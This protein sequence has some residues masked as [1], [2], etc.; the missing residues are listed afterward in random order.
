MHV[1]HGV[2]PTAITSDLLLTKKNSTAQKVAGF[3]F[4]YPGN[5]VILS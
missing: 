4:I 1:V 2:H 5:L 3:F